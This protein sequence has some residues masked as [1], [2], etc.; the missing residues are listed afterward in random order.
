MSKLSE[1]TS[2]WKLKCDV[3]IWNMI[4]IDLYVFEAEA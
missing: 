2:Y 3:E 1:C 4:Q